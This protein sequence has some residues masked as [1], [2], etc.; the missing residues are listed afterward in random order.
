VVEG[1][2]LEQSMFVAEPLKTETTAPLL[3]KHYM[4]SVPE[5]MTVSLWDQFGV[6]YTP[7]N[8]EES[9]TAFVERMRSEHLESEVAVTILQKLKESESG[10]NIGFFVAILRDEDIMKDNTLNPTEGRSHFE[11]GQS[12]RSLTAACGQ[13]CFRG[14]S[15]FVGTGNYLGR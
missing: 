4:E 15:F 7:D 11:G 14:F 10:Q 5:D 8:A 13:K 6:S 1:D 3:L 9:I 12:L 2:E